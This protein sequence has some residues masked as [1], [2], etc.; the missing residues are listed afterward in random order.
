MVND[1]F[2]PFE[3]GGGEVSVHA[4]TSL[5]TDRGVEVEVLTGYPASAGKP[6]GPGGVTVHYVP[7]PP[8]KNPLLAIWDQNYFSPMRMARRLKELLAPGRFDILHS[9]NQLSAIAVL[10]AK[11]SGTRLP[12]SVLTARSYCHVCPLGHGLRLGDDAVLRCGLLEVT[13][14]L[15]REGRPSSRLLAGL[16]PFALSSRALHTLAREAV[17]AFDRY[18]CIS[19]YV[20]RV[21]EVN[22]GIHPDR[23]VTIPEFLD[24]RHLQGWRPAAAAGGQGGTFLYVGR[25]VREKGLPTLLE[26]FRRVALRH[27][28]ARLVIVGEGAMRSELEAWVQR[29]G[30]GER[31]DFT[32]QV[33]HREIGRYFAA[34]NVVVVPSKWPEPLG[35]V[36]LEALYLGLPVIATGRGGVVD[37]L[38]D[39]VNGLL[40][41]P[42]DPTALAEAMQRLLGDP[43][44]RRALGRAGPGTV[45]RGFAPH[46]LL[47]LTLEVYEMLM[48]APAA[49]EFPQGLAGLRD[50]LPPTS[51][52]GREPGAQPPAVYR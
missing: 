47:S 1:Y 40:V 32:G 52:E 22:L 20:R 42:E 6:E 46:R 2:F 36:I 45:E 7:Y 8:R 50:G 41:P 44:L 26:A 49:G 38:K 31:V 13:G 30:L 3:V 29:H 19:T 15:L 10:L 23:V 34:A 39:A 37:I 21:M 9:H 5:L 24:L 11:R 43:N 35:M 28:H 18:I 51:P 25:L 27:L 12:P 4:L 17:H 16:L 33:D 48:S 14:C